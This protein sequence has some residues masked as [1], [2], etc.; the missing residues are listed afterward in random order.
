M[1]EVVVPVLGE[2]ITEATVGRWSVK[3]GAGTQ[4][5]QLLVELETDKVTV[6]VNSPASGVLK[7]ILAQSGSVVKVGAILARLEEGEVAIAADAAPANK[8]EV[9]PL[10]SEHV[11]KKVEADRNPPSVTKLL[12][13]QALDPKSIDATG[14][15]G[16][17]TKTDVLKHIAFP[18][19]TTASPDER[20]PMSRLRQRIAERL[21]EAQNTA[22][23]LT[24]FNE[25]DMTNVMDLRKRMQD[26]FQAK[27]GVKL[28]F[29]S[30]FVRACIQALKE[31]PA[32][33][34]EID[35]TDIIFK[36]YYSIGMAVSTEKGLVVPVVSNAD[37]LSMADI[38]KR[39]ADMGQRAKIGKLELNELS[40][41][42]FSITNGG[43][44]GSLMSTPI[45]NPPQCGILGLHAIKER[46]IAVG[47]NVE[48]RP[49]MYVAL[50]Y[51]HRLVDGRE[52]VSFLVRIKECIEDPERMLLDV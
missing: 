17:L 20:V 11:P 21:K 35:G 28:G 36:H 32:L 34:A 14:K 43:I 41:G 23:I 4:V 30:F 39:I 5:D 49:M 45:L 42:T 1:Q 2:S 40:G 10:K 6:E 29:S 51:D 7:E 50:S 9:A 8:A 46:P 22:A 27:H 12:S 33:N 48:I 52:A 47:K 19:G 37:A 38:E 15:D 18:R 24:T 31:F 25:I 3:L 26:S 13:E 44:F 16:R